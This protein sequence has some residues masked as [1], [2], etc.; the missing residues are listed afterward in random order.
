MEAI[1]LSPHR[2]AVKFDD[3]PGELPQAVVPEDTDLAE[4][5]D[6]A[7]KKLNQLSSNS[8]TDKAIWRDFFT[9]TDTIRTL[10]SRDLVYGALKE[11]V[12]RKHSSPFRLS[13][14]APRPIPFGW[15]DLD[16]LFEVQHGT[17]TGTGAG[18]VSVLQ[19]PDGEWRIW[20]LR[21]WLECFEGHGHPDQTKSLNQQNGTSNGVSDPSTAAY[22]AII[23]GGGQ[24]GLATAGRLQALGLKY[25]LIEKTPQ[26]GDVWRN[27]YESL[28]FHTPK[29]YDVLPFDWRFPEEDDKNLPAERIGAGHQAWAELFGINVRTGTTVSSATYDGTSGMWTVDTTSAEGGSSYK[30]KN[31]VLTIGPSASAPISPPWASPDNVEASGFTGDI[32]HSSVWRSAKAWAGKRGIV[33]GVANTGHDVAEDMANAGM[34]TT[35]VQRGETMVLPVEWLYAIFDRD[36]HPG[37]LTTVADREQATFPN[38]VVR[39]ITNMVVHGLV[40]A[41]PERFDALEKQGFKVDRFGDLYA[42][43]FERFGGHYVDIGASARIAKG[44]IKIKSAPIK[45]LAQDGLVFEDGTTIPA[46]LVV[47]ATGFNHDFRLDAGQIIGEK[48]AKLMGDFGGLDA[49]GEMR[50][51]ARPGARKLHM[52]F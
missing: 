8:L 6:I 52:S 42:C 4:V 33:V 7:V 20:M 10:N 45:G 48:S 3:I 40:R 50:G 41:N 32:M 37:K 1:R 39:E 18:I 16:I 14:T 19:S 23:V 22:D 46:D 17:L 47:L 9:F 25:L 35:M 13:G 12:A 44:E 49:E 34:V 38:K 21:T 51:L 28:R 2:P 27:R 30:A 5:A 36:Y 43:L 31:L 29:E 24:S 11:L 26:I 15:V